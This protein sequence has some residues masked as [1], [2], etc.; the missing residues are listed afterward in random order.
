[1]ALKK[2]EVII[3]PSSTATIEAALASSLTWLN[4]QKNHSSNK[5]GSN[6]ID[7]FF[8]DIFDSRTKNLYR[9]FSDACETE[10]GLVKENGM[11]LFHII[12]ST[13]TESANTSSNNVPFYL[14]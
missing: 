3:K 12:N 14:N 7:Y 8:C 11:I 10:Y 13:P 6:F 5:N 9:I 2:K 1:M 4:G